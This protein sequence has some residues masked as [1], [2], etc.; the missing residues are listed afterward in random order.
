[1]QDSKIKEEVLKLRKRCFE[2]K[3]LLWQGNANIDTSVFKKVKKEIARLKT[4]ANLA[5][6]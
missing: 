6:K 2:Q 5:R 3:M 4:K 1:M